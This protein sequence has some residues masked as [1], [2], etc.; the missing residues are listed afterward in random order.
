MMASD[1]DVGPAERPPVLNRL[2][3]VRRVDRVAAG[4]V[5]DG[6]RHPQDAVSGARGQPEPVQCAFQQVAVERA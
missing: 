3:Q 5:G 1:T 4:Q 6:A 2:A